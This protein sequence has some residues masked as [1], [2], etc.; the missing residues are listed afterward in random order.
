MKPEKIFLT[1]NQFVKEYGGNEYITQGSVRYKIRNKETNG[2]KS[3][4]KK[5]GKR[6]LIDAN[7]FWDII[8]EMKK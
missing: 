2:F 7:E 8:E 1:I 5:V 6:V 4:F 3:A